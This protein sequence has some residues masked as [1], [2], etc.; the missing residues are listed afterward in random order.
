VRKVGHRP[1][2]RAARYGHDGVVC[3]EGVRWHDGWRNNGWASVVL[4]LACLVLRL[5]AWIGC[6]SWCGRVGRPQVQRAE[7]QRVRR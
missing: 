1:T 4:I 7:Q 6:G 3:G 2:E 5:V